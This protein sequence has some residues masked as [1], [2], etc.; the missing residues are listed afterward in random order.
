MSSS[1]AALT[2]MLG[3]EEADLLE[4]WLSSRKP[5]VSATWV[6]TYAYRVNEFSRYSAL[7]GAV[8]AMLLRN[9]QPKLPRTA[10]FFPEAN[11]LAISRGGVRPSR[12]K[13]SLV[14]QHLFTINWADGA[15]GMSWPTAY[16]AVR[17]PIRDIWVVTAS[18]DTGEMLGFLDVALGW[19]PATTTWEDGV[20]AIITQDWTAWAVDRQ[21]AW[22]EYSATGRLSPEIIWMCRRRAWPDEASDES[23][24]DEVMQ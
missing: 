21:P 1:S 3:S 11:V 12:S 16:Y 14:G 7:Q 19:F 20:A 9:M 10:L 5:D 24:T 22:Q 17:L 8:G 2:T 4:R 6:E 15:P 18:D 23:A 13:V